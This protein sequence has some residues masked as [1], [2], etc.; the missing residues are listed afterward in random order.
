M[1]NPKYDW[2]SYVKGMIRRYPKLRKQLEFC[3]ELPSPYQEEY[4]SVTLACRH[5]ETID[6]GA[7]RMRLISLIYWKKTHTLSG[8]AL[9]CSVDYSTAKR[10]HKDFIRAVGAYYGLLP[11][12]DR[13][14]TEMNLRQ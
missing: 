13:T 5:T 3:A 4:D 6:A 10:W 2:W 14:N 8:A 9:Q 7:E 1:S 12:S 11:A